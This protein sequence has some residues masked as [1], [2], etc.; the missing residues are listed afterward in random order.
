[1]SLIII[2]PKG[3]KIPLEDIC[4]AFNK[5]GFGGSYG[6]TNGV[7]FN[8]LK[9][10]Q[11]RDTFISSYLDASND[12]E[13]DA[14][15]FFPDKKLSTLNEWQPF[16]VKGHMMYMLSPNRNDAVTHSLEVYKYFSGMDNISSAI[17]RRAFNELY[18]S[19]NKGDWLLFVNLDGSRYNIGL[20][21]YLSNIKNGI[22]YSGT[23]IK[24][25]KSN[26]KRCTMCDKILKT[27]VEDVFGTCNRCHESMYGRSTHLTIVHPPEKIKPVYSFHYG[28]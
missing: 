26:V 14:M 17:E 25:V 4:L 18:Y 8:F 23:L 3:K 16:L 27:D 28:D 21:P 11:D 1:M 7:G 15:L 6:V 20:N 10:I 2:K 12:Q 19:N 13:C 9:D 5:Y 22:W 24:Q